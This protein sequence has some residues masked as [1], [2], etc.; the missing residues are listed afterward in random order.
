MLKLNSLQIDDRLLDDYLD[1]LQKIFAAMDEAYTRAIE[2]YQFECDGCTDNCCLT[3]FHHHTYLEYCYLLRGF[4]SLSPPKKAEVLEKAAAV[5]RE[6]ALA[7]E[8][9]MPVRLMC[10]L[11]DDSLCALYPYRP[12]ICRMHGIPHQLQKPGH[13]VINVPGCDTFDERCA[14]KL[15][16]KYDRTPFYMKMAGLEKEFK[17]AL[18]VDG[19]IKMTIAEMI[20]SLAQNSEDRRQ[21]TEDRGQ[22]TEDR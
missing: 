18:G 3:R 14:D 12:M 5:C 22:K 9:G 19:R 16:F 4:E 2:H 21:K 10:P 6:T 7:D 17:Q 8:K 13:E 15:Y 20:L 11:N 1:R